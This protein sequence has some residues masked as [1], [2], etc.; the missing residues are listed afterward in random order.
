VTLLK[1]RTVERQSLG[2]VHG[3]KHTFELG[4]ETPR[5]V[6]TCIPAMRAP[7]SRGGSDVRRQ[8]P[9]TCCIGTLPSDREFE[10]HAVEK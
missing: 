1:S 10:L 7:P 8:A 9:Q 2:F 5:S 3:A 6:R 4:A